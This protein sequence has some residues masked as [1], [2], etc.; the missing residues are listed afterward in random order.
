[1][2]KSQTSNQDQ[3][4]VSIKPAAAD[5]K[6]GEASKMDTDQAQ[7][8]DYD[9]QDLSEESAEVLRSLYAP[10]NLEGVVSF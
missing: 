6:E 7:E 10:K 8:L 2:S 3:E 5:K 9:G 4:S 1:M